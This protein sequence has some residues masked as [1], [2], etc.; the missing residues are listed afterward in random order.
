MRSCRLQVAG[1]GLLLALAASAIAQDAPAKPKAY[2]LYAA[3]PETVA[4]GKHAVVELRFHVVEGYHINSHTPKSEW[5]IPTV[6]KLDAADGVTAGT[7]EYPAGKEYSFSFDPKEKL[8][9]YSGDFTV[10]VPVVAAA[11]EH[12]VAGTLRYQACDNAACYPPRNLAVKAVFTA[13]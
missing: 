1:C 2:V 5:L 4:A 6:V 9:V 10:K 7:V 13:K 8:D 12:T 11:G 3:E